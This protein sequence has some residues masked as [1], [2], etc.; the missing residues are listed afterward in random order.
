VAGGSDAL[1]GFGYINFDRAPTGGIMT[2]RGFFVD[3]E[4]TAGPHHHHFTLQRITDDD[5]LNSISGSP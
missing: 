5:I 1:S 2:A 4:L 3:I